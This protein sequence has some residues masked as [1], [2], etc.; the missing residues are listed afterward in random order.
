MD[1]ATLGIKCSPSI[2]EILNITGLISKNITK[3][4]WNV[5]YYRLLFC[6]GLRQTTHLLKQVYLAFNRYNN[7][8]TKLYFFI[9]VII[10]FQ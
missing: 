5:N 10:D 1:K 9:Y 4:I 2:L 3:Y 7:S 6:N 8:S